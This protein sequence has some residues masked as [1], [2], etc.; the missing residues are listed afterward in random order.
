MIK[1]FILIFLTVFFGIGGQI[2]LKKGMTEVGQIQFESF[3]L[4]FP[5]LLKMFFNLR[6]MIGLILCAIG[7]FFWL[8]ILSHKINLNFVYPLAGGIFYIGLLLTTRIFLKEILILPQL[9]GIAIILTG[10]LIL[11]KFWP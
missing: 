3:E 1:I 2:F 5:G 6:V 4:L 8:I 9:I 7:A 11:I 10:I